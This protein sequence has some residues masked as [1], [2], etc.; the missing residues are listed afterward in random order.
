MG[1]RES[2]R[3][4]MVCRAGASSIAVTLRLRTPAGSA[5]DPNRPVE[6][7][8]ELS[9]EVDHDRAVLEKVSFE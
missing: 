1:P 9:L 6:S 7:P 3:V 8:S 4:V 5:T 2:Q